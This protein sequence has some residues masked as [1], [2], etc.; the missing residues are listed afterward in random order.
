SAGGEAADATA[1]AKIA[2]P[3]SAQN[4][5]TVDAKPEA[6]PEA[7]SEAK[8]DAKPEVRSDTRPVALDAPS[9]A[10]LDGSPKPGGAPSGTSSVAAGPS[11]D[12]KA[13]KPALASDGD[14]TWSKISMY[15]AIGLAAAGAGIWLMRRRRGQVAPP[16]SIQIIAQ[17]SLGG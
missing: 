6:R 14:D 16:A 10:R 17:R 12:S 9:A 4:D 13:L 1:R 3:T 5:A 8:S 2:A 15:A 11:A 7:K